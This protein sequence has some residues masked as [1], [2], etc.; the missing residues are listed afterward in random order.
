MAGDWYYRDKTR[1]FLSM[2]LILA[3]TVLPTCS[4]VVFRMFAC[5]YFP[6][7]DKWYASCGYSCKLSLAVEMVVT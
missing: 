1:T 3:Y 6:D 5:E 4:T 2:F 7:F